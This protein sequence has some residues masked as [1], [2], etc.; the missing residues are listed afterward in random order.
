MR[1]R[2]SRSLQSTRGNR[3]YTSN[4]V[5]KFCNSLDNKLNALQKQRGRLPHEVSQAAP[6]SMKKKDFSKEGRVGCAKRYL[7]KSCPMRGDKAQ[8]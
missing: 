4:V 6:D 7:G 5:S 2:P 3:Q 1:S 8:S